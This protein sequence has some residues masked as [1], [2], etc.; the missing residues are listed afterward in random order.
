MEFTEQTQQLIAEARG[1][2][3]AV[4]WDSE[5]SC[6]PDDVSWSLANH[7]AQPG[8]EWLWCGPTLAEALDRYKRY[9]VGEAT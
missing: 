9:T 4:S 3:L 1:Y 8:T 6:D 5:F 2:G 7:N